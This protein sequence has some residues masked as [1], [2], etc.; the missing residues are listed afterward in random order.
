LISLL[1]V[2]SCA[3][4]PGG[5]DL[6]DRAVKTMGGAQALADLRTV[7]AKGTTKQWEPE[8]SDVPGGDMRFANEM[9]F[10]VV[11][12]RHARASRTNFVKNFAYPAP[13]T[14][15]FSEIVTTRRA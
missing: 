12:D 3:T 5:R 14:F 10:E 8:Q 1:F 7:T 4:G 13:R 2:A 6:V 11:A 9:T 15:T